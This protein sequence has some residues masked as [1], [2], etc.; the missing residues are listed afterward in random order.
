[1]SNAAGPNRAFSI[2]P[3]VAATCPVRARKHAK[4]LRATKAA[5]CLVAAR[6]SAY[7]AAMRPEAAIRRSDRLLARRRHAARSQFPRANTYAI[8]EVRV[9]TSWMFQASH[10]FSW[11]RLKLLLS[12]VPCSRSLFRFFAWHRFLSPL[13]T[14]L[15][16]RARPLRKARRP[17]LQHSPL[18]PQAQAPLP[19]SLRTPACIRS[20]PSPMPWVLRP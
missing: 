6:P 7:R 15:R 10:Q 8:T 3:A 20:S 1:M 16:H 13:A 19:P 2:A 9:A 5:I 11:S 4:S 17:L 14:S 12:L 18:L